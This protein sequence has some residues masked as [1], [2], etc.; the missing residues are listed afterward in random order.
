MFL[1][2]ELLLDSMLI[3]F[4]IHY[5]FFLN[6]RLIFEYNYSS[7]HV[8]ANNYFFLIFPYLLLQLIVKVL[9]SISL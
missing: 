4:P 1:N 2:Y 3:D 6:H 5:F 9:F 7:V 8:V